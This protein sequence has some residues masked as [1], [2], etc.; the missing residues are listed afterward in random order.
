MFIL[1]LCPLNHQINDFPQH[2]SLVLFAKILHFAVRIL[3]TNIFITILSSFSD[4]NFDCRWKKSHMTHEAPLFY[5]SVHR[6]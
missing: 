4:N 1:L 5:V 2:Q 3:C 6:A